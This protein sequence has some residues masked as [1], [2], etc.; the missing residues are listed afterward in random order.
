MFERNHF[1]LFFCVFFGL[2]FAIG[3]AVSEPTP[4]PTAV[5]HITDTPTHT[6]QPSAT[7]TIVPTE[8]AVAIL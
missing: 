8:T 6:P 3:C 2:L 7:F 5:S 1:S 4:T